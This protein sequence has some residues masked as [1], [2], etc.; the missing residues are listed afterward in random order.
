MI[1]HH[2]GSKEQLFTAA[3]ALPIDPAQVLGPVHASPTED[4]GENLLRAVT[5]LW[6]SEHKPAILAAFR[7]AISGDGSQLIQSFLLDVVL[8]DIIPRVDTPT[9]TGLIRAELVASQMAGLLVTRYVLGLEPLASLSVDALVP[10]VAPNLQRYLTGE[11][12]I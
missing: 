7:S 2:F 1:H 9:G 11:L 6:E 10:L 3:I 4:L 12:P 8:R 5:G